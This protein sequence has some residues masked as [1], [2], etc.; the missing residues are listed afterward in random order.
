MNH[1]VLEVG[2]ALILIAIGSIIA[3]KLKFSII[4][5]LIVIGMLVGPHAPTFGIID[6]TFIQSDEIIHFLGRIGVLF[7]LFYLGL[8]FSV[9]KLAKSGKN[10]VFGGSIYVA[11][12]FV[13]GV[14]YGL[15]G[16]N[17]MVGNP[18]NCWTS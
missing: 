12:N 15:L 8:E 3:N 6:L 14:I 7:L 11:L 13:L 18:N 2:I 5:F 17:A 9:G 10:I 1:L 4:P 16:R